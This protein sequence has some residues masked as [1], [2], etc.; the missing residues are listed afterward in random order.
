M[1]SYICSLS[2]KF[3]SNTLNMNVF[4]WLKCLLSIIGVFIYV[5][6]SYGQDAEPAKEKLVDFYQSQRYHEAAAYLYEFYTEGS[7]D[8]DLLEGLAYSNRMAG[9]Y[10]DA[11]QYYLALLAID[12]I[13][14]KTLL[15]LASI[16]FQRGKNQDAKTYY[17]KVLAQ[18]STYIG[19]YK[20]LATIAQT[21]GEIEIAYNFL[22]KANQLYPQDVDIAYEL[23]LLNI[24]SKDYHGADSV[25]SQALF[26]DATNA[27]LLKA[28]AQAKYGM[29]AYSE[30]I[31]I[32]EGLLAQGDQS[33]LLLN[34]LA[35]AYYAENKYQQC[36]DA[37]RILEE[38]GD[39][40]E[41]QLYYMAMSYK[42]LKRSK[43]A[44]IYFDKT[45]ESAIS[46]N[47]AN[48]YIEK[49]IQHEQVSQNLQAVN[50]YQKSLQF[51]VMPIT[52]YSLGLLYDYKL[53]NEKTALRYYRSYLKEKPSDKDAKTY[54]KYVNQRIAE[55]EQKQP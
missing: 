29:K 21:D 54:I 20:A 51:T 37:L 49:G 52:Y 5:L 48:Y 42:K 6:V 32:G 39:L 34:L 17:L 45:I 44:I 55:L 47:V 38:R 43:D 46:P 11:A 8:Y 36:I 4:Y 28:K 35:P 13:N 2:V 23:A 9:N 16:N 1:F 30:V 7:T 18:D 41:A 12:T 14:I 22:N 15:N 50:A 27:L 24:T 26:A 25:L 3:E 10:A 53:R 40:K 19:A 33:D 31:A